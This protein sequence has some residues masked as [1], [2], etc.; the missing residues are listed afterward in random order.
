MLS[1]SFAIVSPCLLLF[2]GP[3]LPPLWVSS[4]CAPQAWALPLTLSSLTCSLLTQQVSPLPQTEGASTVTPAALPSPA[5][6]SQRS[7]RKTRCV[8]SVSAPQVGF[9]WDMAL[10]GVAPHLSFLPFLPPQPQH[11]SFVLQTEARRSLNGKAASQ[12]P[13][14]LCWAAPPTGHGPTR[15]STGAVSRTCATPLPHSHCQASLWP[16]C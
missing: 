4:L 10:L 13:S 12:G 1:P 16:P 3:A 9:W 6:L 15:F 14:A 5:T 8:V 11:P 7:V 2:H